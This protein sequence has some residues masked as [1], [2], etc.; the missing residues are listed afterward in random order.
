MG[1]YCTKQPVLMQCHAIAIGILDL[2][3]T[4]FRF[5]IAFGL[6]GICRSDDALVVVRCT[7]RVALVATVTRHPLP[8]IH[9]H[10]HLLHFYTAIFH[11]GEG[12]IAT[13]AP[14]WRRRPRR[15]ALHG[16][17]RN[18]L[19][20]GLWPQV[21][22]MARAPSPRKHP[23]SDDALVVVRC[24]GR[25]A[26]VA[27]VTRHPPPSTHYHLHLLHSNAFSD[28]VG[29]AWTYL[30]LTDGEHSVYAPAHSRPS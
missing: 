3:F 4:I 6:L 18:P 23:R 26:L 9:Y 22:T 25:V 12:A 8:S 19:R 1:A 20:P 10:L 27:T 14:P 2:R 11:D 28:E 24:T 16:E 29:P 30:V 21:D 7:G 15:R 5:T 17:G 13:K